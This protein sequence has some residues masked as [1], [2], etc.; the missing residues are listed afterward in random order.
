MTFI[1]RKV[2]KS[3]ELPIK[4]TFLPGR[5][6]YMLKSAILFIFNSLYHDDIINSDKNLL[7]AKN[8]E[9]HQ[10]ADMY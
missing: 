8:D 3:F 2:L 6:T 1:A 10:V 5:P 7:G 9:V 4:P